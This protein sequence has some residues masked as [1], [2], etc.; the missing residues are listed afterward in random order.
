M[1]RQVLQGSDPITG[2]STFTGYF[3]WPRGE[4]RFGVTVD[5]LENGYLEV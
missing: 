4:V 3:A 1:P 5:V 2:L